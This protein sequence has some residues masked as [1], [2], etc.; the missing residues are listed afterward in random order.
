MKKEEFLKGYCERSGISWA[1]LSQSQ[2]VLPCQCGADCCAGWAMVSNNELSI[3]A[4]N[5][6]CIKR[7]EREG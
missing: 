2:V 7:D 4:H 5:D 6:L 1:E 3:K